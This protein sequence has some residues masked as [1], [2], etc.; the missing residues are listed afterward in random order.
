MKKITLLLMLTS[1]LAINAQSRKWQGSQEL[2]LWDYSTPNWLNPTSPLP[3]PTTFSEGFQAFFDDSILRGGDTITVNGVL[4]TDTIRFNATKTYCIRKTNATD[5]IGGTGAFIKEGSGLLVMDVLT[6]LD[7]PTI[8]KE[9][10]MMMEKQSSP[11][12]FGSR[13]IFQ[14]GTANFATSSSGSYPDIAVP[15]EI[16]AGK[17]AMLEL[18]R[19]SYWF[20][21][22]TGSGDLHLF[23]GG[24]RTYLGRRSIQPDWSEYTGNVKVDSYKMSGVAS[25]FYALM[26]N[27][28]KTFKDTLNGMNIDST[29]ANRRLELGEGV[30]LTAE[31]GSRAYEIGELIANDTASVIAGYYKKSNSPFIR[32]FIGGLNTDV[33][34]YAQFCDPPGT[35][36]RY[37]KVSMVKVGTGTYRLLNNNSNM[38]GG[39]VVQN[40][41]VL[42]DNEPIRGNVR[43]AVGNNV[44]VN[45]MGTIG[46]KGRIMGNVDLS[47]TLKPGSNGIGK[48]MIADTLSVAEGMPGPGK[49]NLS[50]Q[51]GSSAVFELGSNGTC[52]EL[53]VSGTIRFGNDSL[54]VNPVI[55]VQ[56]AEGAELGRGQV[57]DLITALGGLNSTSGEYTLELPTLTNG[58]VFNP[59]ITTEIDSVPVFKL[60]LVLDHPDGVQTPVN[61]V[62]KISPVPV[63]DIAYISS[64]VEISTIEIVNLQG[65]VIMKQ[66][67]NA[68]EATLNLSQLEPGIYFSRIETIRGFET[69]KL[70]VK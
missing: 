34:L 20:S 4:K 67:M 11:N 17:T 13:L 1:V 36:T 25:G 33:D 32:Y 7:G 62:V 59:R 42:I 61:N 60:S 50:M 65:Q 22:L 24:E 14:G 3:I 70:I 8:L 12:I 40:G 39:L 63:V 52:D 43:G 53:F 54:Q 29:M 31:S 21:K 56:I 41:T 16:P 44:I 69:Q 57:F 64:P 30:C 58:W 46:G 51:P 28:N 23:V 27:S 38:I 66:Q 49:Y 6:H 35:T 37:N 15:V 26:L 68:L 9:G 45:P 19:Y 18:S 48:L 55:K 47:G 5:S 2:K 10:K